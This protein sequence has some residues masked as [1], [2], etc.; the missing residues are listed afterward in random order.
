[1]KY[2]SLSIRIPF[3]KTVHFAAGKQIGE[4]RP[5]CF[6]GLAHYDCFGH[7]RGKS[8]R[9][10]IGEFIHYDQ[11][12]RCTGFSRRF[13]L[14]KIQHF[15]SRGFRIGHTINIANIAFLHKVVTRQKYNV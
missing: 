14:Y 11:A 5:A 13:G 7:P 6:K 8:S 3:W 4:S 15:N 9:N 12:G 2:I 1:M 10:Y